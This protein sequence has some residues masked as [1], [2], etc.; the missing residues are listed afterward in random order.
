MSWLYALCTDYKQTFHS[1]KNLYK[2]IQLVFVSWNKFDIFVSISYTN[3][4]RPSF[5]VE[6][7]HLFVNCVLYSQNEQKKNRLDISL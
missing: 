2:N 6:V 3:K 7:K 5:H 4:Y 1:I